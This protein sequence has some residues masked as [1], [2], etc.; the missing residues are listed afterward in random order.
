M[1]TSLGSVMMFPL[2]AEIDYSLMDEVD[3]EWQL[4]PFYRPSKCDV[5]ELCKDQLDPEMDCE[6]VD[7]RLVGYDIQELV[8]FNEDD[9]E[10]DDVD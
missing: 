7:P 4:T 2:Q 3:T 8:K 5:L 10:P 9:K 6:S 1:L